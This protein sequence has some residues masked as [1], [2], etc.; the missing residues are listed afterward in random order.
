MEKLSFNIVT[1][2]ST[3]SIPKDEGAARRQ[4]LA[5]EIYQHFNKLLPFP[6]IAGLIA[7]KG[8]IFM[9]E[10][11]YEFKKQPIRSVAYFLGMVRSTKVAMKEI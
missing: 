8:E 3:K 4:V 7:R 9:R 6:M 11:F 10:T 2:V 5:D 1:K